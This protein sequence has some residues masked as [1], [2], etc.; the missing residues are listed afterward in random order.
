MDFDDIWKTQTISINLNKIIHI[1]SKKIFDLIYAENY[2]MMTRIDMDSRKEFFFKWLI[3]QNFDVPEQ[4]FESVTKKTD[5][6][7][8]DEREGVVDETENSRAKLQIYVHNNWERIEELLVKNRLY[9]PPLPN[10]LLNARR[11]NI[12]NNTHNLISTA[13]E[14]L[15]NLG[16]EL[17]DEM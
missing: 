11:G 15:K 14:K 8:E 13:L 17:P 12:N 16:I 5:E 7:K 10:A 9:V 2:P 1:I 6:A 3:K 4:L